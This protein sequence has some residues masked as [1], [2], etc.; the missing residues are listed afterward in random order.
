MKKLLNTAFLY[1]IA[2]IVC[3]VFYRELTKFLDFG[4][5]TTLAFTHLHLFVLG[6]GV[7]L[8]LALFSLHTNLLEQKRFR[9]FYVTY[10]IGLPLMVTML[11]IRGIFQVLGTPLSSGINAAISGISGLTHIVM[12]ISIVLMFLCL[13]S[14][15]INSKAS[16]CSPTHS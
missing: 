7:F 14:V 2:A 16:G 6:T 12:T 11:L 1:A 4:Q 10:N 15:S 8:I 5:R 13:K 3:G 9:T